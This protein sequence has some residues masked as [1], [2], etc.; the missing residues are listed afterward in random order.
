MFAAMA[1]TMPPEDP[2]GEKRTS[3]AFPVRPN[4]VLRFVSLLARS[5]MF[6]SPTTIAPA[7]RSRPTIVASRGA[8]SSWP[9][10]VKPAHPAVV[11]CPATLVLALMTI[12]TPHSGPRVAPPAAASASSRDASARASSRSTVSIAP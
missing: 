11:I 9:G 1:V 8:T 5:G 6:A 10:V 7:A 2:P 12:G 3:Y 4:D